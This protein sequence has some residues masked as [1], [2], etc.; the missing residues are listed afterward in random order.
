MLSLRSCLV[1]LIL[2]IL[3]S[4]DMK[5][6]EIVIDDVHHILCETGKVDPCFSCSLLN[7]CL[8]ECLCTLFEPLGYGSIHFELNK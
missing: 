7:Y 5:K 8:D 1:L 2:F 3:I 4:S 6:V